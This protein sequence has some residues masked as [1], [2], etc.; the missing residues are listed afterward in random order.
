MATAVLAKQRQMT[1]FS[2]TRTPDK[3][4]ALLKVGVDQVLL[5]DGAVAPQV[6][7]LVP[8]GVD[9][10]LELI[11]TPTLPDTLGSVRV[12]GVV[13]FT[14]MLSNQWIVRDFY[15]IDYLPHGVRLTA[16]GGDASD[17]PA[18]IL[19]DFL[20]A[21]AAGTAV[22][23]IAHVYRFDQIALAHETMEAGR[24]SG[25]LVVAL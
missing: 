22:V 12:H 14:G 15:P 4:A 18:P 5:D 2:T 7:G 6:R 24:V 21:V 8:A 23:P 19:Q 13:C 20:D 16:Y 1:V 17:L 10:A 9:A 25:K 11:G 3:K